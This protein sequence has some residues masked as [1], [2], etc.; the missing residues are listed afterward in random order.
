MKQTLDDIEVEEAPEPTPE[1]TP[2]PTPEETPEP[3]PE[4][5]PEET[6]EP[7]PEPAPEAAPEKS[8]LELEELAELEELPD[9]YE[10]K[11]WKEAITL[12]E[13]RALVR[14][15]NEQ[16]QERNERLTKEAEEE[17]AFAEINAGYD[18]EIDELSKAER[19]PAGEE[20]MKRQEQVWGFI[21]EQNKA[22]KERGLPS[23][24]TSF[25][26]GLD[27]LELQEIRAKQKEDAE[28]AKSKQGSMVGG[29]S[30]VT[31]P[32]GVRSAQ[33]TKGTTLDDIVDQE[34]FS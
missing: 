26:D 23:M 8:K 2:E 16:K 21:N 15:R 3:T 19:L 1:E 9:D 14:L 28:K 33:V 25:E 24:I 11:T 13:E 29:A 20:G 30:R 4:V 6:P 18:R 22:R 31:S 5:E 32:N 27:K 7:T 34:F 12:G 10:A 17:K